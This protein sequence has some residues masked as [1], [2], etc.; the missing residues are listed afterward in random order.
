MK[1]SIIY[2]IFCKFDELQTDSHHIN[3]VLPISIDNFNF[4]KKRIN[5]KYINKKKILNFLLD[6]LFKY[7]F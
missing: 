6:K 2:F 1:H 5:E 4:I 7:I 3:G